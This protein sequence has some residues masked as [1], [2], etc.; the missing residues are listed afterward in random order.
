M[1]AQGERERSS[2]FSPVTPLGGRAVK[3]TTRRCS[4]ESTNDALMGRWFRV[5]E[6]RLELGWVW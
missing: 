3:M 5:E 1:I 2:G 6:E 4:T